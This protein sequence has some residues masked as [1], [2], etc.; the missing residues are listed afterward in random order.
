MC[1][2]LYYILLGVVNYSYKTS[3]NDLELKAVDCHPI[4][5]FPERYHPFSPYVMNTGV[6]PALHQPW[7]IM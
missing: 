2:Y 6:M 1:I 5:S 3:E 4:R 7:G